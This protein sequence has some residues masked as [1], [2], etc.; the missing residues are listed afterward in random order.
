MNTMLASGGY[1]WTIVPLE[2]RDDYMGVLE[3]ASVKQDIK[4]FAQFIGGLVDPSS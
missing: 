4:P 1:P 3:T 2:R